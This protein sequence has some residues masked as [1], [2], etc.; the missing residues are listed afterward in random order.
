MLQS[1]TK[2]T[3]RNTTMTIINLSDIAS[4]TSAYIDNEVEVEIGAVTSNLREGD[5]G[6]YTVRVTNASAP[7]GVRLTDLTLHLTVEPRSPDDP[8]VLLKA[9]GSALFFPR[10]TGDTDD[11]RLSSGE[12]VE[13]MFVFFSAAGGDIEPNATLDV[14]EQIELEFEYH[15]EKRG[16]GE[17]FCH[18][19]ATVDVNSLFPRSGGLNGRSGEIEIKR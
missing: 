6:S 17:I 2:H 10:A 4:A 9:P 13:E 18:P 14:G 11:P 12:E 5:D 1:F 19:H 15:A 3:Q 16:D 8:V 7:S